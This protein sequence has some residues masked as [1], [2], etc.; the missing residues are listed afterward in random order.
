M[1]RIKELAERQGLNI[2][3]LAIKAGMAY[4]QVYGAWS[5][6]PRYPSIPTLQKIAAALNVP[7][8]ALFEGAPD[9]PE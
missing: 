1:F 2:T 4:S 3:T 8:W 9:P 5:N 7:I 6:G